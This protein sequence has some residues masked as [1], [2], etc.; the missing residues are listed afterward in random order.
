VQ[1]QQ[2]EARQSGLWRALRVVLG[3]PAPQG[4]KDPAE[5]LPAEAKNA[6]IHL[7]L[8]A[9]GY[10]R[11]LAVHAATIGAAIGTSETSGR[12]ALKTLAWWGLIEIP[13]RYKGE[14]TVFLKDPLSVAK[15]RL[16]RA[17]SRSDQGELDFPLDQ[18]L[19]PEGAGS[20][21]EATLLPVGPAPPAAGLTIDD[22]SIARPAAANIEHPLRARA[23]TSN[24]KHLPSE[25]DVS[26]QECP[27]GGS[28]ARPAADPLGPFRTDL[29]FTEARAFERLLRDQ[30]KD[31]AAEGDLRIVADLAAVERRVCPPPAARVQR[32]QGWFEWI[33]Q[34]V[35]DPLLAKHRDGRTSMGG[36]QMLLRI[37]HCLA[38][39]S[40]PVARLHAAVKTLDYHARR[41]Q[42]RSRAA[43]FI[44]SMKAIFCELR[45]PWKEITP[46]A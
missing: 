29:T 6:M 13:D 42:V 18:N 21:P 2:P 4:G 28:R 31:Q 45:L 27:P 40:L 17:A 39:G 32:A 10:D 7:L 26:M 20:Q 9:G 37:A 19:P 24:I 14:L 1:A 41:G 38:D 34:N 43:Y 3:W 22:A 12:R 35:N 44:G 46:P 36:E 33:R 30:A 25:E 5:G 23:L 16:R 15:V 8:T 11:S